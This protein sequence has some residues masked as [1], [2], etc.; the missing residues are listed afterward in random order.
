MELCQ[1][2]LLAVIQGL[3]EFLPIS[4][5]AHLV[6]PAALLDWQDQ[7]LAFDV[8]VHVGS[9]LAVLW[10]FRR[11][12]QGIA[13]AWLADL[14]SKPRTQESRL[15]WL[16]IIATTPA[17]LAGLLLDSYIEAHL[18]SAAIIAATTIFF[19]L[20][21]GFSDKFSAKEKNLSRLNL[22]SAVAIGCAQA[23][24]LVP[25]TSRSGITITAALLLGFDRQAAARISFLL[26]I[27]VIALSGG[28]KTLQLLQATSVDWNGII[29]GAL[30]SGITAYL[31]IKTFL[32]WVDRIGMMPFVWYR[33]VLG[34]I[35]IVLILS[36]S[37]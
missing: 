7:G 22:A 10:F 5:S 31:C 3:T 23:L 32:T 25:G 16:L 6:L 12:L 37:A 13:G 28:Y 14:G 4:S 24:A 19:G 35:L 33:L 9:L 1:T 15:G 27:P 36:G 11:D 29:L 18:R 2:I 21:L 30:L 17:G 26:S 20:V 34:G 8:A